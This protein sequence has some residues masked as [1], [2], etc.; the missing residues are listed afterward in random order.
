[1]EGLEK[2]AVTERDAWN[3]VALRAGRSV[4]KVGA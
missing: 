2:R 4:S 1:M 3:S